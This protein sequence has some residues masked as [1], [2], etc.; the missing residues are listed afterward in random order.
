MKE[1]IKKRIEA[2]RRGEVPEGYV[3]QNHQL[4]PVDQEYEKIGKYLVP[5]DEFSNDT[6]AYQLA[7][8]SRQ[9]LMLQSEY[10]NDQRYE[11]TSGGFHVVPEGYVTYRHMSDDDIFRFNVNRM[12]NSVLVSPE[13]PVFTTL[14]GLHQDMLVSYLN[15]MKEF[16]AYCSAQK[17]GSTRTRM[18]F[19]RLGE[20][21]MPIP[22]VKEQQKI[23][24]ILATCDRIIELKQQKIE[25][26]KKAKRFFLGKMFPKEGQTVPEIRF[27]G[28][29]APW[30]QRKFGDLLQTLPFKQFLKEPEPDGKYEIIQQG[31]EP[32]IGFANGTP[33][34]DYKDVVIFGD[35]T[36][37][38]YKPQHP[39]FVATDG[40]RITTRIFMIL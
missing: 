5:Y 6:E 12:G 32:V 26:I 36:L 8:S 33:C 16:K 39:F 40:V 11:V 4:R 2:V 19:S 21:A 30:E 17:K 1:S 20:F 18:Y 31:N 23:A 34:G 10:Y 35:H 28:F 14:D 15:N 29:T 37:S 24:E 22:P 3:F 13:Y 7:T 9:G 27:K 38:L 25:E